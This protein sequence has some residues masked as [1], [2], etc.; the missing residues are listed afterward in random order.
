MKI[1]IRHQLSFPVGTSSAHAV[2]HLLLTPQTGPTQTVKDW[3]IDMPGFD[4]AARMTDAFGNRAYLVSQ[5]R[6]E[7]DLVVTVTGTVETVD[8][9]GMLGRLGGEPVVALYK[10]VTEL[11]PGDPAIVAPVKAGWTVSDGRIALLHSLMGRIGELY[12]FGDE[13]EAEDED[14]A[15]EE[16]EASGAQTQT[17][18]QGGGGEDEPADEAEKRTPA[19][20]AAFAHMFIGAAR[21]LDIPARYVTGYLAADD[22]HPA[23]FHAW[24]EAYDDGL[25]WIGFDAA[26]GICP[27]DRH[28]RLAAGLDARSTMPVRVAPELEAP[29]ELEVSVEML[30]E[31]AQ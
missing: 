29:K 11:T 22:D 7:D 20:A 10:R 4:T 9:N 23:A 26:L 13:D 30:A 14:V 3:K 16:M 8:R 19:D 27:T 18:S 17:Q 15:P 28:V 25:G 1:A 6:P 5:T 24:A 2:Q 21:A 12:S 31:A